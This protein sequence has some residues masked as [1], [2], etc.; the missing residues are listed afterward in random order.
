MYSLKVVSNWCQIFETFIPVVNTAGL[1]LVNT[2][3]AMRRF[4][5][6]VLFFPIYRALAYQGRVKFQDNGK[7]SLEKLRKRSRGAERKIGIGIG[8]R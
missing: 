1:F 8:W 6:Q 2:R 7:W 4:S 3:A 5:L